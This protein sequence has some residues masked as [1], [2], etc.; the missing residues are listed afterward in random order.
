VKT[1]S[2]A[3]KIDSEWYAESR[4]ETRFLYHPFYRT[5]TPAAASDAALEHFERIH[6]SGIKDP[7]LA[8]W[9]EKF[10]PSDPEGAV[11][12]LLRIEDSA[13]R[14]KW[15]LAFARD[16]GIVVDPANLNRL[17]TAVGEDSVSLGALLRALHPSAA[18]VT[19]QELSQRLRVTV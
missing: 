4:C 6:G 8:E 2:K 12:M 13:M 5:F 1:E 9:A 7:I 3:Q 11:R 17:I 19:L 14:S 15:A 16:G 10:R 18:A